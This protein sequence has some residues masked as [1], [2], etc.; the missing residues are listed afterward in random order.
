MPNLRCRVF[1]LCYSWLNSLLCPLSSI[2]L[3]VYDDCYANKDRCPHGILGN[4][5]QYF[6]NIHFFRAVAIWTGTKVL[7]K[8]HMNMT[9]IL[10][11]SISLIFFVSSIN[12][13]L[14]YYLKVIWLFEVEKCDTSMH[15]RTYFCILREVGRKQREIC[16]I[17]FSRWLVHWE[18]SSSSEQ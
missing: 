13:H 16:E 7:T 4:R 2:A 8:S 17:S 12:K 15:R 6:E 1:K 11:T 3:R 10:S 18:C 9:E 14:K 5:C